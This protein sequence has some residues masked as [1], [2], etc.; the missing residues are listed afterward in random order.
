MNLEQIVAK[1]TL[2]LKMFQENYKQG[3]LSLSDLI[4]EE[5]RI[6]QVYR[7]WACQQDSHTPIFRGGPS[8]QRREIPLS[9]CSPAMKKQ[10][11]QAQSDNP[12][13]YFDQQLQTESEQK[14]ESWYHKFDTFGYR[15]SS[16][17]RTPLSRG[18]LDYLHQPRTS[19]RY[20]P[21]ECSTGTMNRVLG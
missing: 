10:V 4:R 9:S 16:G 20:T 19:K 1:L 7:N 18:L 12:K 17:I 14:L 11:A 15:K 6:G 5:E 13:P 21:E 3:S 2:E 8:V